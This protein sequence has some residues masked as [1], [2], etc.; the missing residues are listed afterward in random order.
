MNL[1]YGGEF[2]ST[3]ANAEEQRVAETVREPS[4]SCRST[5]PLLLATVSFFAFPVA[6]A[7]FQQ[8]QSAGELTAMCLALVLWM[9]ATLLGIRSIAGMQVAPGSE[10]IPRPKRVC[11]LQLALLVSGAVL[12]AWVLKFQVA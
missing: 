7:K 11:T 2:G 5:M 9:I 1:S 4:E 3:M 10:A 8:V 12:L 6:L